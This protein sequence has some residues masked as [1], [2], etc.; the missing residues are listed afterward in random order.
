GARYAAHGVNVRTAT[1]PTGYANVTGTSYAAPAVAAHLATLV[2]T[3]AD[4][5]DAADKLGPFT[6]PIETSDGKS[7]LLVR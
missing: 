6:V 7:L 5:R 3:P 1:L 4:A 2:E